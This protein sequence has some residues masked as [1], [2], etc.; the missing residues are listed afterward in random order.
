MKYP[1]KDKMMSVQ[2]ADFYECLDCNQQFND[3]N[4]LFHY[5]EHSGGFC[6]NCR[7]DNI[8]T[9]EAYT[10]VHTVYAT[11]ADDALETSLE[12]EGSCQET[13]VYEGFITE[14]KENS[15]E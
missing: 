3:Y 8:R 7:S 13:V 12:L 10:V 11:N 14:K 2:Y 1:I 4:E 9:M 15:D 5:D 6:A